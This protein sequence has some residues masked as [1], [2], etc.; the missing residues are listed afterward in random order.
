MSL[1]VHKDAQELS[2]TVGYR[3]AIGLDL[4]LHVV[5]LVVATATGVTDGFDAWA[6]SG[7]AAYLAGVLVTDV[8]ALALNAAAMKWRRRLAFVATIAVLWRGGP[9]A[10]GAPASG[11]SAWQ[12]ATILDGAL[13]WIAT[14][15][16]GRRVSRAVAEATGEQ[17]LSVDPTNPDR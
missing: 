7:F 5:A 15:A 10:P 14:L 3:L 13:V 4:A 9:F 16:E 2:S 1:V 6:W 11:A 17:V 8:G 12:I